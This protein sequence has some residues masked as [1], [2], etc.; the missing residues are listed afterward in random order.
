MNQA[1]I[2]NI[3]LIKI[4][5]PLKQP[6]I[7]SLGTLTAAQSVFV[8]I[9]TE[10]GLIGWGECSPFMT[11]NG[12]TTETGIV[13]GRIFISHLIGKNVLDIAGCVDLLDKIIYGNNSIKSA[14]DIAFHDIASQYV[15]QPLY[16]FLGGAIQKTIFTDYTVSLN[17]PEA[18]AA[19]AM[20]IKDAGFTVIKVKLGN[21]GALDIDRIKAIRQA[22]GYDI[23]LRIDANQGWQVEEAIETLNG[24]YPYNIQHAEEPIARWDFMNLPKIKTASPIP[25]MSDES[26]CDINDL[27]RLIALKACDKINIKLGKCGGLY[28]AIQMLRVA[29]Q[30]QLPVQLGAFLESR[31]GMTAFT[32]LAHCSAAIRYFD[33]DTALMFSKDPIDGGIE[34]KA[35]GIIDLPNH[36]GLGAQL[37]TV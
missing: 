20:E 33:F 24:L 6:F 15:Q 22:I 37:K 2:K 34:Y 9:E 25:I 17:T 8:R 23:P 29:E 7:I 10:E 18:M 4:D 13:V 27:N 19:Q 16:Q 21:K 1:I 3:E 31:L 30:H 28:K 32:H 12:E 11:I 35:N 36:I 26:C 5:I 14:F